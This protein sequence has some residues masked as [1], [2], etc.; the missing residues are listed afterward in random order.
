[1]KSTQLRISENQAMSI[2]FFPTTTTVLN[3]TDLYQPRV[4]VF[5]WSSHKR[6]KRHLFYYVAWHDSAT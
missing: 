6:T 5:A 3:S 2:Y 1:M 4:E